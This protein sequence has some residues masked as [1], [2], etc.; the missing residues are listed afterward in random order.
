MFSIHWKCGVP[1]FL[2]K[3]WQYHVMFY[4]HCPISVVLNFKPLNMGIVVS[5]K[6]HP[7]LV[8]WGTVGGQNSDHF[9]WW[10]VGWDTKTNHGY[11]A[12]KPSMGIWCIICINI[13][14]YIYILYIYMYMCVDHIIST[15]TVRMFHMFTTYH[16]LRPRVVSMFSLVTAILGYLIVLPHTLMLV[17]PD[18]FNW[19]SVNRPK[20][21]EV[22]QSVC[23]CVC[24]CGP[25]GTHTKAKRF[26]T[27]HMIAIGLYICHIKENKKRKRIGSKVG[28]T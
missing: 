22:T 3:T 14:I 12:S 23:V 1:I 11:M 15:T 4:C 27:Q 17:A 16:Y 2:D 13:H 8:G 24:L 9:R 25:C 7:S 19:L 18:S 10:R 6:G 21:S 5:C 26:E 28:K 20:N